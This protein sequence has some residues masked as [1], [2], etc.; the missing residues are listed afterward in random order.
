[1][2][3]D[4]R[5]FLRTIAFGAGAARVA[6][7]AQP[8]LIESI[9][10][11][12][13]WH[14]RNK[15]YAWFHPRATSV[16]GEPNPTVLMTLQ[17]IYGSD[18]FGPVHWSESKDLG[19]TWS[20]PAPIPGLGRKLNPDGI[21]EGVC[22]VV[23]EYHARTR[24][25]LAM[26]HNVYYKDNKLTRPSEQR[27]PVYVVRDA[28]GEWTSPRRLEW[29]NPEASAMY[30]AG[31]AQRVPLPNGDI[32]VPLSFGPLGRMDR[33]VCSVLCSFD[34]RELKIK[35]AGNT[36]RLAVKRGLLE[37]SL[38]HFQG[39]YFMT[40]RAEDDRGYVTTS[41][42]GL[43]WAEQKAWCWDDGEPLTLST[44]QQRWLP[45]SDG[46]FLVYTRK[47][48]E[49]VNVMRWRAP[50]L[51][52]QVDTKKLTLIRETEQVVFPL[53]GDGVNNPDG[54]ALMGNFH[55]TA[56]TP[57]ESFVTVGENLSKRGYQGDTLLARIR[58][59]RR[60]SPKQPNRG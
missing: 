37:P 34:G 3:S 10:R 22:D 45:H 9:S 21:E 25:I 53:I 60:A 33:G 6:P 16:P 26:G 40:I 32:L 15:E 54:V 49:N 58:W 35:Q 18:G 50:L 31:C 39:R 24:T 41:R 56:V 51:V 52:A 36:L 28:K 43:N 23:P 57:R 55:T 14:G 2:L 44:T 19:A 11:S 59:A 48:A 38:A 4:R 27:W 30:T 42:D 17:R 7:S 20:T 46:L 8:R 13:I 5:N 12:I 29:D 47:M 1:M